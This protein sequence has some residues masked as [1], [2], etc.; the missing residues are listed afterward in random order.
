MVVIVGGIVGGIE[1]AIVVEIAPLGAVTAI[2]EVVV[3]I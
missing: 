2:F 3:A 1:F